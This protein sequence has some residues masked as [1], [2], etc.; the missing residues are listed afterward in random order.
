MSYSLLDWAN[1]ITKEADWKSQI[2]KNGIRKMRRMDFLGLNPRVQTAITRA[3][4]KLDQHMANKF[5]RVLGKIDWEDA[6][7]ATRIF[8]EPIVTPVNEKGNRIINRLYNNYN[9]RDWSAY[10][11][12]DLRPADSRYRFGVVKGTNLANKLLQSTAA[13]KQP[14]LNNAAASIQ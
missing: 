5:E 7:K 14:V 12:N 8:Q 13:R 2:L 4:N 11:P 1:G 6:G 3:T 10:S 9:M